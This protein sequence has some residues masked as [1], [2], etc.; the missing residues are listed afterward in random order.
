MLVTNMRKTQVT[1]DTLR[2]YSVTDEPKYYTSVE[3]LGYH[4]FRC[5]NLK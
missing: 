4:Q 3:E 5:L 1:S 2:F